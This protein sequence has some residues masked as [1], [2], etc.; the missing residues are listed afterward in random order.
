M[1]SKITK[2][3]C[4][5][6]YVHLFPNLFYYLCM[7][8]K[9]AHHVRIRR[10]KRHV[11]HHALWWSNDDGSAGGIVPLAEKWQRHEQRNGIPQRASSMGGSIP[12]IDSREPCVVGAARH[13][14]ADGRSSHSQHRCHHA[15]PRDLR[16][17]DDVRLAP[18]V[19]RP[20]PTV[21]AHSRSNGPLLR[22]GRRGYCHTL[23]LFRVVR[24]RLQ[25]AT[26]PH[27]Y[28]ILCTRAKKVRPLAAR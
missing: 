15:R 17:A 19:T 14:M 21:V 12:G 18:H 25:S 28:Y 16:T 6:K 23:R 27:L 1:L 10:T 2:Y 8:I 7:Q 26:R 13:D 5:T 22:G 24:R 3:G 20:S 9:L 4:K 11:F